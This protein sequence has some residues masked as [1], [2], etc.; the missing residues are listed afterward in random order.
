MGRHPILNKQSFY[1]KPAERLTAFSVSGTIQK[2]LVLLLYLS[3]VIYICLSY[4]KELFPAYKYT[5]G[6]SAFLAFITAIIIRYKRDWAMPLSFVYLTFKGVFLAFI[7]EAAELKFEGIVIQ[8]IALCLL[9]FF[10]MLLFYR[11]KIIKVTQRLRSI[12]YAATSAIIALYLISFVLYWLDL[13]PIPYIHENGWIGILFSVFVSV[14]ASFHLL[15]D[16]NFFERATRYRY[17]KNIEWYAAFGLL[18]T[19]IWQYVSMLRLL[20]KVRSN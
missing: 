14:T 16:F 5:V 4:G 19:I 1:A 18:I 15:L 3:V 8:A 13:P 20:R 6:A 9:V 12:I 7:S 17:P 10:I 2:S 11:L